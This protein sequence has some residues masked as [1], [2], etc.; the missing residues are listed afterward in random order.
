MTIYHWYSLMGK[1]L[2]TCARLL[3][4]HE[5]CIFPISILTSA[6]IL[7]SKII[8]P[9]LLT[10]YKTVNSPSKRSTWTM[11]PLISWLTNGASPTTARYPAQLLPSMQISS[12]WSPPHP[13]STKILRVGWT[14]LWF[15]WM[16]QIMSLLHFSK[17]FRYAIH[18]FSKQFPRSRTMVITLTSSLRRLSISEFQM[19]LL[20][21]HVLLSFLPFFSALSFRYHYLS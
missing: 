11:A 12:I 1:Q 3:I 19:E 15:W 9:F 21:F 8:S 2:A 18:R 16:E 13:V 6:I 4:M 7:S 5:W 10:P 20:R 17:Y 14:F